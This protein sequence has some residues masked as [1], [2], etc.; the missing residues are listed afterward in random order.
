MR[1]VA[2]LLAGALLGAPAALLTAQG[3]PRVVAIGDIHGAID[4]FTSILKVAGLTGADGRWTGGRTHLIQTGDYTDR[5]DGTRAVLDLLMALEPQARKAGGRVVSLLGNHEVMNLIGDTRDV[6]REIFATF[7]DANSEARRQ[8]AWSQYAALAAARVAKGA[9]VPPV[10]GQTRDAWLTTHPPGYVEYREA[11]A[12]KGK[13]GRW[14]RDKDMVLRHEGSIFMHAGFDPDTAPPKF[15]DMNTLLRAEV[16]RLDRFRDLLV[17][18]KLALPFFTLQE[19]LQVASNEIGTANALIAAA[20]A[21]GKQPDRSKLNTAL[22]LEAQ[23]ILKIDTWLVVAGD[24]PLWYR[25]LA[26]L[27]DD[28]SGGPFAALLQRYDARRFVTGHTPQQ[29]RRINARFGGRAILIDT[30]MLSY[31]K[32]R[33]SA[34]LIEGDVLTAIYE[35]GKVPLEG[36]PNHLRQGY[37]GQE[38]GHY[39]D[40]AERNQATVWRS[41]SSSVT[42]GR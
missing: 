26:T 28:A 9:S 19:I 27:P 21:E 17:A 22:L 7:A 15:D 37:G 34:L 41:P 10:Y 4:E 32:G 40:D 1:I 23:E 38:G 25:G 39:I 11:F 12:P 13:Y 8:E 31:Y 35:D 5:G 6:T 20:Q 14:L 16:R 33:A 36:P 2:A 30:G 42:V 18:Q 3:S 24:G 29:N